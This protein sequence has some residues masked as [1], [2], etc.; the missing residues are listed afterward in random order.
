MN[1]IELQAK[2]NPRLRITVTTPQQVRDLEAHGWER[3]Q[4]TVVTKAEAKK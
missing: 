4:V 3:V 1:K 2:S